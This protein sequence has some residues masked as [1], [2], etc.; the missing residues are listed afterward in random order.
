M[1]QGATTSHGVGG[2]EPRLRPTAELDGSGSLSDVE[3]EDVGD[4][5]QDEPFDP[6]KI[7]VVTRTPTLNLMLA[8]VRRETI[9]LQPD[10]QRTAGIWRERNQSRLIESLLLRI[11][12]PTFY[13]AEN[14]DDGWAI[15]DG[16]QRLTTITRFMAPDALGLEP[17]VLHDL[18][19]LPF[20]G[21]RF[22]DLPGRLQTR[23]EETEI[24]LHLIRHGTPEKVKFNIFARINTGGMPLSAQE[25]R[26]ALIPG[27]G[28]ELLIELAASGEFQTATL[29]TVR[30]SRMADREMVLR[31]AAFHLT[32]PTRY[33]H[34]DLDLFLREAMDQINDLSSSELDRLRRDFA[35]AMVAAHEI[36]GKHAFRKRY[37]RTGARNPINRAL[38]ETVAVALARRSDGELR[39]LVAVH[40]RV[41]D[42]FIARLENDEQFERAV[43]VGTGDPAKVVYRFAVVDELFSRGIG[44][45]S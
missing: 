15:V 24:V 8:R 23:L 26:H 18:E 2:D 7:D 10:F 37:A 27:Q 13:A 22:H 14:A 19:Y 41:E 40:D 28:R 38:F 43:S 39:R 11:P 45:S 16:I 30:S 31:F 33:R 29:G 35:R 9:D 21:A 5:E 3:T 4:V 12:L 44:A 34:F 1:T 17:L 36:F 42:S 20:D 6:E 25:L 32:D